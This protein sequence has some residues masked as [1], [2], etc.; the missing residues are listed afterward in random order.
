MKLRV[1]SQ[2]MCLL[3][4]NRQSRVCE[5]VEVPR[6]CDCDLYCAH[7]GCYGVDSRRVIVYSLMLLSFGFM[8]L[9]QSRG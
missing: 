5:G 8:S 4:W 6:E 7:M 9:E 1:V 2:R 3:V